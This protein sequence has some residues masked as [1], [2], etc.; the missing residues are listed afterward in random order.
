MGGGSTIAQPSGQVRRTPV[1]GPPSL[2]AR[3]EELVSSPKHRWRGDRDG[4]CRVPPVPAT[5]KLPE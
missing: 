5:H 1:E 3:T 4:P 2:R